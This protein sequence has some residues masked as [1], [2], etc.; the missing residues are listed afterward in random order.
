MF[1]SLGKLLFPYTLH[2]PFGQLLFGGYMAVYLGL[3]SATR[4]SVSSGSS[5][6]TEHAPLSLGRA[7]WYSDYVTPWPFSLQFSTLLSVYSSKMGLKAITAFKFLSFFF[8]WQRFIK[9]P[10]FFFFIFLDEA[11]LCISLPSGTLAGDVRKEPIV[12]S[13]IASDLQE[14]RVGVP[15]RLSCMENTINIK[16]EG[17]CRDD[18]ILLT[19][20][21]KITK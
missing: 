8:N 19:E 10:T 12:I 16:S 15:W 3:H 11:L 2:T 5:V 9:K 1:L 17:K 7:D 6:L 13:M 20:N 14:E 4:A 21:A 18:I